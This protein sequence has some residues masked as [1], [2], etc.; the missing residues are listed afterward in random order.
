MNKKDTVPAAPADAKTAATLLLKD[1]DL[2]EKPLHLTVGDC[3]LV[4]HADSRQL[5]D[6]LR[7]YFKHLPK[8]P[9]VSTIEITAIEREA[10]DTGLPFIDWRREPG[11][12]GRKD[13]YVEL[14][15]GRLL[16]KVR[17]GMLFLQSEQWRIAVGPCLE[18]DNQLVN[19]INSQVMNWLQQRDWLICHAAGL[20]LNGRAIAIAGF[21]GGGKS[22]SMLHLMEHPKSRYLTNDRLFLR[23][24]G[25]S[26]E[27]V[28]IP[29]LPRINPGALVNSPRLSSLID[30]ERRERLSRLPKQELWDLEEKFD[31]DVQRFYGRDRIDTSTPVPLAGLVIL[32][33]STRDTAPVKMTKVDIAQRNELLAAVMKSPGPFYQD[34]LGGF[35]QDDD[36]LREAPYQ[37]LLKGVSVYEV[38]GRMDFAELTGLCLK[39]WG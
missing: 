21:S 4:I 32:N 29:K 14:A 31:V 10:V 23:R 15:D 12:R 35:L 3:G 5:L 1:V 17:T 30:E 19:F 37:Q 28:G 2:C 36:P 7:G 27:A 8:K 16:L 33:W 39:Q 9:V 22:T 38:T 18:Y 13:A 25:V 20:M 11:K 26:V 24:Q 34:K 6:R